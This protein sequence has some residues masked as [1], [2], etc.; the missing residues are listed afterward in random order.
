MG[1]TVGVSEWIVGTGD[2]THGD[3]LGAVYAIDGSI[4]RDDK[5][6]F[7]RLCDAIVPGVTTQLSSLGFKGGF[8]LDSGRGHSRYNHELP[9]NYPSCSGYWLGITAGS[10]HDHG[11]NVLF[12]DGR[13]QF[14]KDSIDPEVWYAV[15]TRAG[16]EIVAGDAVP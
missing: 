8:W 9:P 5:R 2:L 14:V 4:G 6:A 10:H 1:G 7:A 3:R 16:G 12:L 13:V 15:G 11:V